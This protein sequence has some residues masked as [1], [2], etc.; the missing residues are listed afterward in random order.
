MNLKHDKETIIA[1]GQKLFRAQGY[2]ATGIQ[3]ILKQANVSKGSFYN[4]FDTKEDFAQEVVN[5]YG[6]RMSHY[7][8]GY[9][10]DATHSPINRLKNLYNSIIE[11]AVKEDC[12]VGCLLYNFSFEIAGHSDKIAAE[13]LRHFN[14]WIDLIELCLQ[15]A[16]EQGEIRTDLDPRKLAEFIHT[17]MNGSFGR[18]KMER[19]TRPV[20]ESINIAFKLI[21]AN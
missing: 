15:Q 1:A 4:Y 10:Q 20:K 11:H 6:S 21:E 19:S 14:N 17:L 3:Q 9:L 2:N 12:K 13:S 7:I 16:A 5:L 18:I 8:D